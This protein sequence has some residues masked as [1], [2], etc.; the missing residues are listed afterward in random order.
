MSIPETP[1]FVPVSIPDRVRIKYLVGEDDRGYSYALSVTGPVRPATWYGP[2][3]DPLPAHPPL[4]TPLDP[5][6]DC[7]LTPWCVRT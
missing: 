1:S 7:S 3:R 4:S 5:R 2:E 6:E